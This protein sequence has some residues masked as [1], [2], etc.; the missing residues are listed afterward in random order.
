MHCSTNA[1]ESAARIPLLHIADPLGEAI[2]LS[3]LTRPALLGSRHTMTRDD[4]LLG[5]LQARYGLSL[6]TPKGED[7]AFVDRVIFE[8]FVRGQ[9]EDTTRKIYA[10]IIGRLVE[11]SADSVIMGCT[12]IPILLNPEDSTVPMFDTARLHALAAV[13]FALA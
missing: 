5:R 12:E 3:G 13:D 4:I 10:G 2:K 8:E 7:A 11:Q 6:L 1:I 9:F